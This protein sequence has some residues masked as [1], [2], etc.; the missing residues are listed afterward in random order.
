MGKLGTITAKPDQ[1]FA[2]NRQLIPKYLVVK[3]GDG[4]SGLPEMAQYSLIDAIC[5]SR[6]ELLPASD[7]RGE[8]PRQLSASKMADPEKRCV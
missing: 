4:R 6:S 5:V 3:A 8:G 7:E 2:K 1:S